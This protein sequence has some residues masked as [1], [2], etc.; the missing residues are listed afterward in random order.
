MNPKFAA[1]AKKID[2]DPYQ[3]GFTVSLLTHDDI[4]A[5]LGLQDIVREALQDDQKHH[6]KERK[7]EDLVDHLNAGMPLIGIKTADG[8][9]VAQALIS[10]PNNDA[11]KNIEGYPIYGEKDVAA[12]VQS[13]AIHP[14][15]RGKTFGLAG[16]M[17]QAITE[18]AVT[19]QKK[20][21]WAKVANSNPASQNSFL[22]NA[23][24]VA[25][26][27]FDPNKGYPVRYYRKELLTPG[28][29]NGASAATLSLVHNG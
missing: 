15:Y 14:A 20:V 17:H 6:L 13:V 8:K 11:A 24:G 3:G 21:L 5:F 12:I 16:K 23:F 1:A 4:P 18:V 28:L 7:S 29:M 22:G 10:F 2:P 26:H 9:L 27:G 25:A 19:H